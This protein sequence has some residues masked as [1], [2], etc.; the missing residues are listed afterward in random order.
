VFC[1][2]ESREEALRKNDLLFQKVKDEMPDV[3]FLS[4]ASLVPSRQCQQENLERWSSFWNESN[5]KSVLRKNLEHQ[6][7][8]YGFTSSAFE[9]FLEW[10]DRSRSTFTLTE[11]EQECNDKLL[12]A[13]SAE[14]KNGQFAILSFV[15]DDDAITTFLQNTGQDIKIVSNRQFSIQ[16]NRETAGAFTRFFIWAIIIIFVLLFILFHNVKKFILAFLPVFAG[17]LVM[18]AIMSVSGLKLNLFNMVAAILIMGLGVDYGIFIVCTHEESP[19]NATC[20]AVLVSGLTTFVGFGSLI[21]ARHPAMHSIGVTVAA[22]IIPSL[23]CALTLVPY[24]TGKVL[25]VKK[26]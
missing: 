26:K 10:L 1:T 19:S 7:L 12:S 16:L 4:L 15:P 6:G 23:L 8:E 14:L 13:F 2:G 9:P 11:F 20:N 25:A 17:V 5:N 18:C 22:G 21:T 3:N 24:L